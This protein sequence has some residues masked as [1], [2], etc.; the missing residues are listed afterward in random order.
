LAEAYFYIGEHYRLTGNAQ[1]AQTYFEKTRAL[2][3][4]IYIEHIAA[5][6]ELTRL[7]A[8]GPSASAVP[9]AQGQVAH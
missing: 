3:V 6:L 8:N 5:G 4:I 7:K 1:L 2:G 9:A